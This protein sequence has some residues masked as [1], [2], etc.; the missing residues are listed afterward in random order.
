MEFK[1]IEILKSID[2]PVESLDY[3]DFCSINKWLL[4]N[5][6][7][8]VKVDFISDLNIHKN[9]FYE[10]KKTPFGLVRYED[11]FDSLE[12]AL[13]DGIIETLKYLTQ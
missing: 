9:W 12:S 3:L 8:F 2:K 7:I 11:G 5:C 13:K 4:E 10:I 1:E 6:D